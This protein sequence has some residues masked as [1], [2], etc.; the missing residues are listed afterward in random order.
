M[1]VLYGAIKGPP[2]HILLSNACVQRRFRSACAF[3][4]SDQNLYWTHFEQPMMQSFLLR[5]TKTD[6]TARMRKLIWV[7][8]ECTFQEV[9]FPSYDSYV[10]RYWQDRSDPVSILYKSIAGRYRPV[11]IADGPITARYRFVKNASWE[12]GISV[13]VLRSFSVRVLFCA[14]IAFTVDSRYLE[15]QETLKYFEISV[16]YQ[17]CRIEE[18]LNRTNT[19][20]KWICN[21]TSEVR[22]MLK[23][24]WKTEEI[25]Q[26][27]LFSTIFCYLFL[28]FHV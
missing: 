13:A 11:R 14:V 22:D 23:I 1:F 6:Q 24:L 17:I 7:F 26:F 5:T 8:V 18:K 16:P 3:G 20:K 25:A 10:D 19:F 9:R 4:Q 15:V 27:L 12:G 21:L 2:T 28:D